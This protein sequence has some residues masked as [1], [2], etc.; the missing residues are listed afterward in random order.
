[1]MHYLD[2]GKAAKE[3]TEDGD[4]DSFGWEH[5]VDIQAVK[6]VS[7]ETATAFDVFDG[8]KE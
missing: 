8:T 5:D 7:E 3:T 4:W 2:I 1:M 6:E